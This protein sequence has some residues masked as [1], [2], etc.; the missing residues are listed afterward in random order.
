MC[1]L[2][3]LDMSVSLSNL[4]HQSGLFYKNSTGRTNCIFHLSTSL[5]RLLYTTSSHWAGHGWRAN[6]ALCLIGQIVE[7]SICACRTWCVCRQDCAIWTIMTRW[8]SWVR[9]RQS[10]FCAGL[11]GGAGLTASG[12]S[13]S[14]IWVKGATR[15]GH[16]RS[17]ST[18]A[19]IPEVIMRHWSNAV[20]QEWF[21][22]LVHTI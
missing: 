15:A 22:W 1:D 17:C 18:S 11:A 7:I 19:I 3:I 16:R 14:F 10:R 2:E 5:W 20:Q 13:L 21:I 6:L 8:A 9:G 12:I 4:Y